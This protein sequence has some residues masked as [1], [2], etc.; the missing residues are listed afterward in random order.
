LHHIVSD[1]WSR[2]VI[3]RDLMALYEASLTGEKAKA[4][5]DLAVQYADYAEWQRE[6]LSG[7]VLS[8]QLSYWKK[9]LENVTPLELPTDRPRRSASSYRGAVRRFVLSPELTGKLRAF[10]R[11]SGATPFMILLAGFQALL[12]RYTGQ[13]DITVGSPIA[14]RNRMELEDLIGFFVNTLVMRGDVSGKPTFREL[15]LRTREVAI[16]AFSN[17]D[18]P[19]DTLVEE[20]NPERHL[21]RNPLFQ[22]MFAVQNVPVRSLSLRGL[23]VSPYDLAMITTR[24]DLEVYFAGEE[25]LLM[26]FVYSVDLFDAE[27]IDRMFEHFRTLLEGALDQPESP[28]AGLPL[29]TEN[30]N[31]VLLEAN[32]TWRELPE[33][34][35]HL[36]VEERVEER[37]EAPAVVFG[38]ERVSYAELNRR[39][40]QL[41]HYLRKRGVEAEIPVGICAERSVEAVVGLLAILKSGGFYVPLDPAYPE[42]RLKWMLADA[43]AKLV[44]TDERNRSSFSEA[45]VTVVVLDEEGAF[46][47]EPSSNPPVTTTPDSLAYVIYTSGSTG[48]PKGVAVPH[49]AINRLIRNTDYVDLTMED[50]VAQASNLSFDAATFEIWGALTAGACLVVIPREVALSPQQYADA[51]E[52]HG[53]SAMFLTTALFNQVAREKVEAFGSVT[54]VLFGGEAVDPVSVRRVLAEGRP[55]R[56]LHVYGPTETTTFAAWKLVESVP[57]G[58]LT[59]PIGGALANTELHVLDFDM[60]PVPLGVAGELYIGGAGLA[61]GYLHRPELTAEKFVPSPF[62]EPGSRLYRTGDRTRRRSDG[63]LEFLGRVD[64][65]V[66]IRGFRVE[67]GEIESAV[68]GFSGVRDAVV[69]AR[70]ESLGTRRLVAYLVP[71]SD[72]RGG[73]GADSTSERV[74]RWRKTYDE[75]IYGEVASEKSASPTFNIAGWDSSYTGTPLP[76]EA[77]REQVNQTVARIRSLAPERILEIGCGTGLLLF[78]LAPHCEKYVATD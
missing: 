31:R 39:A 71:E 35:V 27:T 57:E 68:L 5:A 11:E 18:L 70:E 62:G 51:I 33:I 47:E 48:V 54:H 20:I 61:R 22:V 15:V 10:G 64:H 42:E 77:M 1:G 12:H 37:P 44:L 65:Q 75:V 6:R 76:A 49:R 69:V 43:S 3:S 41:A 14:N 56:L 23:E 45:M 52:R 7:D 21:S 55:K 73:H 58:A 78:E 60:T 25:S 67:P 29:L 9:R 40:N 32:E 63:A 8:S 24:F 2:G 53:I 36:L 72:A 28:I 46:E 13:T 26:A 19:F 17:Q 38:E 34:P 59:V 30:E 4:L 74:S 16:D 66:K 50:R